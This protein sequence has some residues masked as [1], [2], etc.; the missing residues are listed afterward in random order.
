MNET[1]PSSNPRRRAS[2]QQSRLGDDAGTG[3]TWGY[4][5]PVP[6]TLMPSASADL[7]R[8]RVLPEGEAPRSRE[9]DRAKPRD[10]ADKEGADK[11]DA[12]EGGAKKP[13]MSRR[14]KLLY[15]LIGVLVVAAL[16]TAGVLYWLHARH[17][18]TTDDA[19]VDGYISQVSA[20]VAGRVVRIAFEDNQQVGAGQLLVA[21]DPRDFQVRLDQAVSQ[22]AQSAA[23]LAQS[24]AQL[25]LQ[26]ANLDQAA[27]NVR[28]T[29]ADLGQAQTDLARYRAI[30]PKAITRQQLDTSSSTV[31]SAQAR[32]DANRQAVAGARAQINAQR[33][34]VAAAEASLKEADVAIE[35]AQLQL[36]YTSVP[37][38]VEGQ[39]TKRTVD[40]GDYV[41]AGQS[42]LAVVPRRMWVT[43]N[44]KETQ[45]AAMKI[46][47]PVLIRVDACPGIDINAR[48]NSFQAGTGSAF[49]VL[50]AENATGNYVK[51]VQRVPVRLL[52]DDGQD[53]ARCRMA[54]GMSVLPRVTV[55]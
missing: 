53:L 16:I 51:V 44:F 3:G 35:N 24:Q 14:K 30:D 32:L 29:E 12:D 45:L 34:A 5:A 15:G 42:L 1:G 46:G 47:Q 31:R 33:A 10:D 55:R 37:A 19:F 38:P 50:P 28:V 26:Q 40:L 17:F 43:A 13:P 7:V 11:E 39:V 9:R 36:S 8:L 22:R 18:E 27:A 52:F 6:L 49:S 20:Q 25:G 48:V 23:Q 21:L 54:P 41:S 2:G 4:S